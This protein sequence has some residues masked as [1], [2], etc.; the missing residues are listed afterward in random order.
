MLGSR[1]KPN[2]MKANFLLFT[3]SFLL[4][5]A[6]CSGGEKRKATALPY[7]RQGAVFELKL[8]DFFQ[9]HPLA[10]DQ[11]IRVDFLGQDSETSYHVAQVR[12]RE[13][14][15]KHEKSDLKVIVIQ[16]K[17]TLKLD[18]STRALRIWDSAH[19]PMG[20]PHAFINK[21]DI[22]A[23]AFVMFSPPFTKGDK[24]LVGK[25]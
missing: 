16:G 20:T 1:E 4:F 2:V 6:G 3:F 12:D 10:K 13:P 21:G 8:E 9:N 14:F 25:E 22:L 24:V 15:H 23:A 11:N 17:G 18:Q 7:V 5:L 19:V